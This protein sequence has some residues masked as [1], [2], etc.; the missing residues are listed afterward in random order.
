MKTAEGIRE[1]MKKDLEAGEVNAILTAAKAEK[2]TG[3]PKKSRKVLV[4]AAAVCLLTVSVSAAAVLS[5]FGTAFAVPLETGGVEVLD[6]RSTNEDVS[7]EITEVWFDEYNLYLGGN[8]TTPEPLDMEGEYKA[9]CYVREPEDAF[10]MMILDIFPN[11]T[12]SSPFV[13]Q[14]TNTGKD[15]GNLGRIGVTG[16]EIILEVSFALFHD[17]NQKPEVLA[18]D[19]PEFLAYPG[20]WVYTLAFTKQ[21]EEGILVDDGFTAKGTDGDTVTV[22]SVRI[23]PFTLEITG[24]HLTYRRE[25]STGE[26]VTDYII[27]LKMED[28]TLLGKENW[29]FANMDNRFESRYTDDTRILCCFDNPVDLTQIQS[30]LFVSDWATFPD[31]AEDFLIRDGWEYYED[32]ADPTKLEGW[33][34]VM[35]IPAG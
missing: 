7:W 20:R 26:S 2:H 5:G 32:P 14:T 13:M 27:W 35:E 21:A 16:E 18:S 22:D 12:L 25:N 3:I 8:V 33:K 30:I 29:N 34:T 24:E 10:S 23:N 28:G 1:A 9:I 17:Q 6:V 4:L 11:G 15:N 19:R 31:S